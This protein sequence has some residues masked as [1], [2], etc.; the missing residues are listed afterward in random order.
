LHLQN[1][2][3]LRTQQALQEREEQYRMLFESSIY[4][5]ILS[6]PKDG[7]KI[8]S[9]N[10]AAC[11]MFGWTEE[12][13]FG[14]GRENIMDIKDPALSTLLKERESSGSAKA[15]LHISARTERHSLES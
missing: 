4:A 6:D 3:L 5:I 2:E 13:L 9:A 10:P 7:G 1:E 15:Q 11:Q 14:K 12:E 8:L